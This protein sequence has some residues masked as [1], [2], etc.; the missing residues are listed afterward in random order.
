MLIIRIRFPNVRAA[1]RGLVADARARLQTLGV[2]F[3][4]PTPTQIKVGPINFWPQGK[5]GGGCIHIDGCAKHPEQGWDSFI[6]LLQR[7]DL[8]RP[9][10]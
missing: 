4:Q 3:T 7:H 6:K 8:T 1:V 9:L 2:R 10:K 5:G